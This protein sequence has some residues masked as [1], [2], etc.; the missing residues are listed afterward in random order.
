[1]ALHKKRVARLIRS[2]AILLL[3]V[4]AV[5]GLGWSKIFS[6][7]TI[8][9]SGTQQ[10][11]VLTNTLQSAHIELRTGMPLARVDV[12]AIDRIALQSGWIKSSE[13]S[14]NWLKGSVSIRVIERIPVASYLDGD[15]SIKYFDALGNI[16]T[17][18]SA[19]TN[20]PTIAFTHSTPELR[21]VA[22]SWV[23]E[24]PADLLAQMQNLW[25]N[26]QD[27][28]VMKAAIS[29]PSAKI[30]TINWGGVRDLPLKVKVLRALLL[31][32]ENAQHNNFDLSEPLAP[33]TR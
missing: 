28:I 32:P 3:I 17:T 16:F 27:R 24:M 21:I 8:A 13:I 12:R 26:S 30:I 31:R 9:I 6:V 15:G 11:S 20:L 23:A 22:A 14:R 5:Y 7:K 1:M 33:I 2:F 18:P 25:V 19:F 4:G 10:S 29:V